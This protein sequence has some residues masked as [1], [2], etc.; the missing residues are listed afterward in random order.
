ME[1]N[2]TRPLTTVYTFCSQWQDRLQG[3]DLP[4]GQSIQIGRMAPRLG[5]L[6]LAFW[7]ALPWMFLACFGIFLASVALSVGHFPSY[8]NPDP[9]HVDGLAPLYLLTMQLLLAT[10]ASPLLICAGSV[11]RRVRG[12]PM[13]RERRA[14]A[15]Y[16]TGMLM[17]SMLI[18]GNALGLGSWLFD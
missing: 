13:L 17:A 1:P 5:R 10:A 4:G 7:L 2:A 16:A 18:L 11:V 15:G 9:K 14:L 3:P 6:L 8:S 12:T